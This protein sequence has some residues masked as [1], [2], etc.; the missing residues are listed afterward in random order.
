MQELMASQLAEKSLGFDVSGCDGGSDGIARNA[1]VARADPDKL[2]QIL[3]NLLTNAVKF[4]AAGG[5]VGIDCATS[6]RGGE[7]DGGSGNAVRIVIWD[8]GM[9]I[10][11]KQQEHIFEPFVQVDRGLTSPPPGGVGLGL[12]I[13]R[14]LARGM[15]GDL[16]VES[17]LGNGSRFTLVLPRSAM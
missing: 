4:T 12:A 16:T 6:E 14:D 11:A 8:T 5:R 17:S 1:F 13:S 15:D 3:L 10:A 9:G 2:R 7:R